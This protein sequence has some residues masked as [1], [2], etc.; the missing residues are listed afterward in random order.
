MG[1]TMGIE[2]TTSGTTTLRS[3][4]LSYVHHDTYIIW[5]I[6]HPC[7][8]FMVLILV[9]KSTCNLLNYVVYYLV[10]T[11]HDSLAQLVEHLTFNE[12]VPGSSPG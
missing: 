6:Y 12:G 5:K 2:P 11:L 4:Q 10:S 7:Q 8:V 1:W 3:N 9:Q